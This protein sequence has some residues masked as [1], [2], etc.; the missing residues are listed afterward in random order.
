MTPRL[1]NLL[2]HPLRS[3][4]DHKFTLHHR[5]AGL[6]ETER[7]PLIQAFQ[8]KDGNNI[9][10]IDVVG[11]ARQDALEPA[12]PEID[13]PLSLLTLKNQQDAGSLSFFLYVSTAVSPLSVVP[14]L[15]AALHE[16]APTIAFQTPIT[17]DD[18]L[19]EDLVNNRMESWGFGIFT[20]ITAFLVATGIYGLLIQEVVSNT[21]DFGIRMALGASRG[22]IARLMLKRITMLLTAGLGIGLL[23]VVAVRRL[24]E[25]VVVWRATSIDPA[26]ALRSE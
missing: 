9:A 21:R 3:L 7:R 15:R 19:S 4:N 22:V 18:Q 26:Q 8:Q 24:V 20:G 12:R 10:I 1:G 5:Y 17:M 16:I 23:L 14:Q 11:D 2:R 6:G 13:F 25:G